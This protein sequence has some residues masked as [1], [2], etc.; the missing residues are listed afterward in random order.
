MDLVKLQKIGF[1]TNEN[2]WEFKYEKYVYETCT[3]YRFWR[4]FWSKNNKGCSYKLKG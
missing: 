1:E 2:C 3:F 4:F